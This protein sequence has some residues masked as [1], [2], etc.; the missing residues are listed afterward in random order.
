MVD[1]NKEESSQNRMNTGLS[2]I[3]KIF[4]VFA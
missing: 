1:R 4:F 3:L 2:T